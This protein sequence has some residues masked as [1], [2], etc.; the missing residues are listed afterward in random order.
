MTADTPAPNAP[1]AETKTG[2]PPVPPTPN[3]QLSAFGRLVAD[4]VERTSK[5]GTN[6]MT[7]RVAVNV[8]GARAPKPQTW[9]LDV[10]AFRDAA[11]RLAK[12]RKGSAVCLMGDLTKSTWEGRDGAD[13]DSWS[14]VA[15][16]CLSAATTRRT[17]Q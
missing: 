13:R 11:A 8:T 7:A 5:A 14:L 3:A 17:D 6:Y 15:N 1:A 4:P 9:F 2:S 16:D 12:C 10:T